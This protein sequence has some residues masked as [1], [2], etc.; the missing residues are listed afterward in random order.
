MDQ[1]SI[2]F[3]EKSF[4]NTLFLKIMSVTEYSSI[5]E[6]KK[7]DEEKYEIWYRMALKK[8][9]KVNNEIYFKKACFL[10]EF[11]KIIGVSYG[12][13]ATDENGQLKR[14]INNIYDK[15]INVLEKFFHVLKCFNNSGYL[16]GHNI[17]N[18]DIPFLIKR[19]MLYNL[20]IPS[21]LKSSLNSKPWETSIID[22][23]NLWKF[24]GSDFISLKLIS[25]FLNLK[26]KS[27]PMDLDVISNIYWN[28]TKEG[29]R[30]Y[31]FQSMNQLNLT[32]QLYKLLR[33][34]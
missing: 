32:I 25:N 13:V 15:E 18:Y 1:Y 12:T 17:I 28:N 31:E 23:V 24:N 3:N 16:C 27:L 29:D 10:P 21:N 8:Y 30:W 14:R 20:K 33:N 7:N 34:I 4:Y 22:T 26:Y 6:F 2:V 19:G 5:D 9:D 11:S